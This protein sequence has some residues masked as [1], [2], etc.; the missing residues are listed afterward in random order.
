MAVTRDEIMST[1]A[2]LELPDG[3]TLVSRDM[4]RALGVDGGSVR[5]VI[6]APDA[7]VAAKMEPQ[8]QA[9]EAAIK[10]LAGVTS[11]CCIDGPRPCAKST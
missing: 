6:E 7:S 11:V 8:R 1:L 9:A 5:F 10:A 2:R 3:G 4:V